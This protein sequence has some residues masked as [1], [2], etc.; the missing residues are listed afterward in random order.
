MT[1]AFLRRFDVSVLKNKSLEDNA[2]VPLPN[3]RVDFYLQGATAS[4]AT[5]IATSG[6]T[7]ISVYDVGQIIAGSELQVGLGGR[8]VSVASVNPATPSVTVTN[9]TGSSIS[10]AVGTRLI[11]TSN[12][13]T[14]YTDPFGTVP[15]SGASAISADSNGRA[16]CYVSQRLFDYVSGG[17]VALDASSF[18]LLN[19]LASTLSWS[20]TASGSDRL[21]IVAISWQDSIGD[22]SITGVTYG[23]TAMSLLG[24]TQYTDVY[25]LVD[26][27]TGAQTIV[28]TWSGSNYKGA[29]GEGTSFTGV[30]PAGPIGP[31]ATT[32]GNSASPTGSSWGAFGGGQLIS[33]VTVNAAATTTPLAAASGQ[34]ELWNRSAGS[35]STLTLTQGGGAIKAPDGKG[36]Y[37]AMN[38]TLGGTR[39][40]GLVTAELKPVAAKLMIDASCG[41]APSP[42]WINAAEYSSLEFAIDAV[43]AGGTLFIPR[44]DYNVP[45]GGL[46][47]DRSM[48]VQGETGTRLFPFAGIAA[49]AQPIVDIRANGALLN[50]VVL[51]DLVL[52][53]HSQPD[54]PVVGNYGIKCY[55]PADGSKVSGLSLERV[56]VINMGDD[57]IHLEALGGE[58]DSYFV[59]VSLRE[60]N[61]VLCR[62]R[63]MFTSF[64]NLVNFNG[65][66]FNH[67]DLDG[68]RADLSEVTFYA[69][70]F[71]GNCR[72]NNNTPDDPF[73]LSSIVNGQVYLRTCLVSRFD[74]CHFENFSGSEHPVNKRGLVIENS[75]SCI[76]SGCL[77]YNAAEDSDPNERGIY[78]TFG[79]G[80][81]PVPGVMACAILPNRFENVHTPI[82]VDAGGRAAQDCI[83]FPQAIATTGSGGTLM[84]PTAL[85]DSGVVVLGNR[86]AGSE[87]LARGL[88][89]P[90]RE[91]KIPDSPLPPLSATEVGYMLFDITNRT[92]AVWDGTIWRSVTLS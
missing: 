70:A 16:Q 24:S 15:V 61:S 10:V 43:P 20:H 88:F 27:P 52:Q 86:K 8:P 84:L 7:T 71:E 59:F 31:A 42:N 14:V 87:G 91:N 40:W 22:E 79:G 25:H 90:P 1:Q 50:G 38:W 41:S 58:T 75:Q 5:T 78:C 36:N 76:V 66:Y 39:Q 3:A 73:A 17:Q 72:T 13:P 4:A 68:V 63:G 46:A 23:G 67:N 81:T 49:A 55:V 2:Q 32:F 28:V 33:A 6:S 47:I 74:G 62:G 34:F 29:V 56:S 18:G 65:C 89:I 30:D 82:E 53:N 64:A 54:G 26:P 48:I 21:V 83:V 19:A 85:S 51:R 12:R 57:G 92:I 69:S 37:L 45:T 77:F 35:Y 44:G 11:V 9:S 60:V 80:E